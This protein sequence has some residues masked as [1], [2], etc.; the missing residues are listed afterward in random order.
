[1]R[2]PRRKVDRPKFIKK[3]KAFKYNCNALKDQYIRSNFVSKLDELCSCIENP[4]FGVK[5]CTKLINIIENAAKETIPNT[6]KSV[7]SYIWDQDE[8]L[9]TLNKSRDKLDRRQNPLEFKCV[10]KKISKRFNQLRSKYYKN[11]ADSITE[12]GEARNLEKMFRLSKKN[13]IS[14]KP[15]EAVC[16]GLEE[17]FQKHF[18]HKPPSTNPPSEITLIPDFIKRLQSTGVPL[19]NDLFDKFKNPPSQDEIISVIKKMKNR[20]ATTDVPSEFLK[21]IT[22]SSNCMSL[23]T[24]M[25]KE[26]WQDIVLADEWRRQ[27]ITP[28]YKNKGSRKDPTKYRGISIGS[29]FLKLAMSIALERIKIWYNKQIMLN[30]NGFR[31][32]F[33]CPDAIFSLKSLHHNSVRLNKETYLLFIDLTAAYDWCVRTWLFKSINNRLDPNDTPTYTCIRIMEELYRKTEAA[34]KTSEDP[35]YFEMTSGVRQ[36]GPESPNLFNLYLDYIM[37]IYNKKVKDLGIVVEYNYRIKDQARKRGETYRGRGEFPWLGYA[38]DLTLIAATTENLQLAAD[39]IADLLSRFG[40]VLSLDKTESMILNYQGS[41]YPDNIISINNNKIKNV[42]HF[43]YL[44][45]TISFNEVGT[46]HREIKNR[47]GM[48]HGKFSELKKLLCN[49]HL[50]LST[51]IRFYEVYVRSRLC[52]CCETWSLLKEQLNSL[53]ATHMQFLRRMVRGGME[54]I[55]SAKDMKKLKEEGNEDEINWKWKHTNAKIFNLTKTLSMEEFIE[56]QNCRWIAHV[57]RAPNEAITKQ[58]LFTE[59]RFTL[60]GRRQKTVYENVVTIQR[61]KH[62]KSEATFLRESMKKINNF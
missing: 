42:K 27:T 3:K 44:G 17:H 43:K 1:M 30:Q 60:I 61:E 21:V 37:R 13:M 28:L 8:I 5:D 49:Y 15:K 58:L 55:T 62:G 33:G 46:S 48:A 57:V 35:K 32:N 51:R 19:N 22:S 4:N 41:E 54:R 7:E 20:K 25:Y 50:K 40:L 12:A 14:G 52:Y 39:T 53:E 10:S 16:E 29:N 18:N 59:E 24:S 31:K 34:L 36:G 47:I 9:K 11:L 6:I 38:D 23:L 2:T 45:S 56:R 26:V